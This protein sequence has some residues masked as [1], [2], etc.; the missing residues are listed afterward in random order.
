MTIIPNNI[1]IIKEILR[2]SFFKTFYLHEKYFFQHQVYNY[3][4]LL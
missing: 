3:F 1:S 4:D 2:C